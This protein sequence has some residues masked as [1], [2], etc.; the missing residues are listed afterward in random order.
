MNKNII[1]SIVAVAILVI[2]VF[3][4]RSWFPQ[5]ISGIR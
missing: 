3:M 5:A 2:G 4:G 1:F